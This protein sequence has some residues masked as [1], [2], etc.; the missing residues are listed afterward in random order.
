VASN[1]KTETQAGG[2]FV[3]LTAEPIERLA[4]TASGRF[5]VTHLN[6]KDRLA[7][8]EDEEAEGPD[9]SALSKKF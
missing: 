1:I 8:R 4:V 5:D 6:I 2:P 9:A 3:T 7:G